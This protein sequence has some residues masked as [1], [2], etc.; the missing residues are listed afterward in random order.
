ME[1]F[2]ASITPKE[3]RWHYD[4][5]SKMNCHDSILQ[6]IVQSAI[7]IFVYGIKKDSEL[8]QIASPI[9][10]NSKGKFEID[11]SKDVINGYE[12]LWNA[13]GWKRGSILI[14]LPYNYNFKSI[15]EKCHGIGIFDNP[16]T[17]NSMSAIKNAK[18]EEKNNNISV[19]FSASNGIEW[20]Q[21]YYDQ[22]KSKEL[23]KLVNNI[24]L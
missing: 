2:V 19:V 13:H 24:M 16:N 22:K 4:E 17:G 1:H 11:L 15:L 21:V 5:K 9:L 14:V 7:K 20:M 23:A 8:Y 3:I 10:I 18:K 12:Y 6:P